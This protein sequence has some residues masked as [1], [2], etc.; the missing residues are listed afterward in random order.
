VLTGLLG[1]LLAGRAQDVVADPTLVA[2]LAAAAALVHGRAADRANPGGPVAAL[3]VADAL[4]ATI[5][6][7]LRREGD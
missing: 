5:A 1:A 3:A 7:V 6:A 2:A 4:P